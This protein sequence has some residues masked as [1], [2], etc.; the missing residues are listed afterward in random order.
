MKHTNSWASTVRR[1]QGKILRGEVKVLTVDVFDTLLLRRTH[2]NFVLK[3]TVRYVARELGLDVDFVERCR[4]RSW[5]METAQSISRGFDADAS[6]VSHFE[7]WVRLMVGDSRSNAQITALAALYLAVELEFETDCL[8]PNHRMLELLTTAKAA[9]VRVVAISDMYLSSAHLRQLF[10][11]HGIADLVDQVVTSGDVL[12]QKRTGRLFAH[13]LREGGE[14]FSGGLPHDLSTLLHIGDDAIADGTMAAKNGIESIVTYDL[15][16][17]RHR[18]LQHYAG[19]LPPAYAAADAA[20]HALRSEARMRPLQALGATRFGPVYACFVHAVAAQAVADRVGS[21]WFMAREG[22]LLGEMYEQAVRSG[23]GDGRIRWGYLYASRLA[24][25]RAQLAE[26]GEH[27]IHSIGANTVDRAYGKLLAPLMV[28]REEA[29]QILGAVGLHFSQPRTD[30]GLQA[31]LSSTH[32]VRVV[33]EIGERERAGFRRYL[34]RTGFP[35]EGR[36]AVV[37]VGWGGQIQEN[38]CRA[39]ELIGSKVEVLGYYLGTDHR[40]EERRAKG[41]FIRALVVDSERSVGAG[42]GAFSFV[43]GIELATRSPHGSVVGYSE[44]GL[45]VLAGE[46]GPGRMDERVDDPSIAAIQEGVLAFSERYFGF[47]SLAGVQADDSLVLARDV[48]DVVSLVPTRRDA[49]LLLQFNNVANLGMDEGI[50]LGGSASL[51]APRRLLEVLRTTLWQEGTL[52][53]AAPLLGPL[54]LLAYRRRRGR[55]IATRHDAGDS[56]WPASIDGPLEFHDGV[57]PDA[58]GL[59]VPSLRRRAAARSDG[60]KVVL[61]PTIVGVRDLAAVLSIRWAFRAFRGHGLKAMMKGH[62][63]GLLRFVYKYPPLDVL[64]GHLLKR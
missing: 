8:G 42:A 53:A 39:L 22:W 6:V 14:V 59:D 60:R 57:V 61:P 63:K 19:A 40:A 54:A 2:P 11:S 9:G 29:D 58:L 5:Q 48:I 33:G 12:L 17:M 18:H 24:T 62:A 31:L 34:E 27:E 46:A 49:K 52:A 7:S 38:F 23:L 4:N 13:C 10:S 15:G 20:H 44:E 64:K 1:A 26:F 35:S 47:A 45:P 21:V 50:R 30:D 55:M 37:D 3:A 16:L 36:V 51:L 28:S 56:A 43:Q 41:L 25:M 32:F